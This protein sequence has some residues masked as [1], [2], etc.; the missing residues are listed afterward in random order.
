MKDHRCAL[1]AIAVLCL[2]AVL[3]LA[4][5][6]QAQSEK[7][8]GCRDDITG[9]DGYKIRSVKVGA[10][11]LPDLPSP[12]PKPGTDYSPVIVTE[13]VESVH[14][15]LR[16]EANREDEEGQTELELLKAVTIGKGTAEEKSSSGIGINP[17][18]VTSCTKV[19]EP[20]ACKASL[21]ESSSQ[22]VDVTIHA[23]S[24][25][26]DTAN[27]IA[28]LLNIPRSNR[29]SFLSRVPGPLLAFSPKPGFD[30]DRSFGAAATFTM[31]SN[32]LDLSRNIK[33]S[34][35]EPRRTR[36][37]LA[38]SGRRSLD[39]VF[40]ETA[41]RISLSRSSGKTVDRYGIDASF[42]ADHLPSG[43]NEYLKN[44]AA[45]G[46]YVRLLTNADAFS[47]IGLSARYRWSSNRFISRTAL[48]SDFASESTFEGNALFDGRLWNGVSRLAVWMDANSPNGNRDSYYRVAALWGYQREFAVAVN[49]TIG[50]E[51]LVGGGRAWGTV[52]Q[53]AR[54][55]GGN[56][57]R[58]FLYEN[59]ESPVIT[60]FPVGPLLRS[61]GTAQ[62]TTGNGSLQVGGTSYW[63]LNLNVAVPS[64]RWS[65]P[66]V[67]DVSLEL[68]KRDAHGRAVLDAD[69][70]PVME[71]RPLRVI[72]KNQGESSRKVLV[73]TFLKEGM[74][75]SDAEAKAQ[76]DLKGINSILGF[77]ADR[78]NIYSLKPLFMFDTARLNATAVAN[79]RTRYAAGGG[80]QLTI[81]I[82]KF[83]AGYMRTLQPQPGDKRGNFVMRL[84][85]QNLF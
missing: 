2:F 1:S 15:A 80:L 76:R 37:D 25:R 42:A 69:G 58:N 47:N 65:L 57:A 32:L 52:P 9:T 68:P 28:N 7:G 13:L 12:L 29:P 11:Y 30:Y 71:D 23:V 79:N 41:G 34:P 78:A 72:L 5:S 55:Y 18:L 70:N 10:R 38:V 59:R 85:F 61:F 3:V 54:F 77:I 45:I 66:L 40:Y 19:V 60:A 62:A 82:A 75:Q 31:A 39:R 53:Y 21:G 35:L 50:V 81:V 83:E 36:L 43:E 56:Y 27:P 6:T 22:C 24:L 64:P 49:Q 26:V 33:S 14:Q 84:I 4:S 46:G 8:S 44:A 48:A 20:P 51:A 17:K 16:K 67:P 63:N 74:S 73:R